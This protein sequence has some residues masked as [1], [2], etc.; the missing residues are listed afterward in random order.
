[1]KKLF[2]TFLTIAFLLKIT[3]QTFAQESNKELKYRRSSLSMILIESDN[4]PNKEAV[5][6]SWN[7][8][9][10]P[11][12]YN[13][14]E[15]DI[16]SF[17]IN[18]IKLSNQDLLNA[19]FLKDTLKNSLQIVK[20]TASL[21]PV[22]YIND[23]QTIAVV[24]PT[25]KQDYQ[26]KIDKFIR[27]NKLANK[28]IAKW[29][30]RSEDGKFNMG[31]I[32]ERGF[33]NA[34]ELEASVAK[35]QAKGLASLGDAGEELIK[36]TFVT[37]T[38]LEFIE[39]EPAAALIRDAAKA[40]ISKKMDGKP[41][42]IKDMALKAADATYEKTKE[43]YSLWSKTWLYKLNW[44]DSTATI[45]YND[46]WSNPK[47]F[48]DSNLFSLEFV[49]VQYNQSLVTFKLGT[50]RTQEQ[51]I[52]I[53][54]VRNVDNAFAELQRDN[55]VFKPKVP[56]LTI[57]PIRAEIG[58]KESLQ[59]GEKFEVLEM[60]LNPNTGLTEYK[61]LGTVTA[62]KDIIWDN[63]YNA[64]D[65]PEIEQ[66]DETGNVVNATVF[67]GSK[68]VQPGMLLKQLK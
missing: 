35:G 27:E 34:S 24:M 7:N 18:S 44:N 2:Y 13:K 31:L 45:F 6:S 54:L 60:V 30:N 19:G 38:K 43:G 32:Q 33:Y 11:N 63:R 9:P 41:Q 51:L 68:S 22:Q 59:G 28:L 50:T 26:L 61:K 20:A 57:N 46:L 21:K 62:S 17:N 5:M 48:D 12:K 1:M 40:E 25:D 29:F 55:D 14:H 49:G 66:L 16:K 65:K 3:S 23:E 42:M 56:V 64:G 53:A 4:F 10:F 67:K 36:N 47:A 15:I 37:F 8:Y 39:N 52:D 58:M